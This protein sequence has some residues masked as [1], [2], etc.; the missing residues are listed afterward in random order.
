LANRLVKDERGA[1]FIEFTVVFPLVAILSLGLVDLGLIMFGW[2]EGNR[3]TY[4]GARFA[5]T[6]APVPGGIN[7]TIAPSTGATN[8]MSC[9]DPLAANTGASSG[10]CVLPARTVCKATSSSFSSVSCVGGS[11]TAS[12]AAFQAIVREMD[13]QFYSRNLDPRQVTITYEPLALGYVG[14]PGGPPMNVTVSLRC[15]KQEVYFLTGF[16]GWA[17]PSL[18]VECSGIDDPSGFLLPT[19]STTL[20]SEDLSG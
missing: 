13:A 10:K 15:I 11:Y 16:L 7:A 14:R 17:L 1:T 12:A 3:A 19:F 18:P 2:A 6:H 8:G 20:P 5:V 9:F 4:V